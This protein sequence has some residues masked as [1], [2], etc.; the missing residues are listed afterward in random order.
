MTAG[1][2]HVHFCGRAAL[3]IQGTPGKILWLGFPKHPLPLSLPAEPQRGF[4]SHIEMAEPAPEHILQFSPPPLTLHCSSLSPSVAETSLGKGQRKKGKKNH[5]ELYAGLWQTFYASCVGA[6]IPAL[7]EL[8]LSACG[9]RKFQV[10]T[11]GDHLCT[12]TA[13]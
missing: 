6:N 13:H 10:D 12:C 2:R 11:F 9:R 1:F 3:L 5:G 4:G 7:A 8:P